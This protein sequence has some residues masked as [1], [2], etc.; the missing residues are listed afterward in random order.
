M[1]FVDSDP[2]VLK[3]QSLASLGSSTR[4]R[5]SAFHNANTFMGRAEV[6]RLIEEGESLNLPYKGRQRLL[7]LYKLSEDGEI[8][9]SF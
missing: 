5:T 7:R 4:E 1:G 2:V 3:G 6:G 8:L 9:A